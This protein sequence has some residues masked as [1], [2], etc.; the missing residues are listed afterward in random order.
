[1]VPIFPRDVLGYGPIKS[2]AM[3]P[4]HT[5]VSLLVAWHSTGIDATH[6]DVVGN[7]LP[8]ETPEEPSIYG[9]VGIYLFWMSGLSVIME[10]LQFLGAA[11]S[12]N[13]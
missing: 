7:I 5:G 13:N 11:K 4:S 2:S 6:P 1:M 9:L 10:H 3:T 8:H 12:G